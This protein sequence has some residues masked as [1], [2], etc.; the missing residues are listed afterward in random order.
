MTCAKDHQSVLWR[1]VLKKHFNLIGTLPV[2]HQRRLLDL[3]GSVQ[4][5]TKGVF[6]CL[7]VNPLARVHKGIQAHPGADAYTGFSARR[8]DGHQG[9]RLT[10]GLY[11]LQHIEQQALLAGFMALQKYMHGTV[12]AQAKGQRRVLGIGLFIFLGRRTVTTNHCPAGLGQPP[13]LPG[14]LLL[15]A[16]ATDGSDC[17]AIKWNQHPGTRTPIGRALDL[18]DRGQNSIDLFAAGLIQCIQQGVQIRHGHSPGSYSVERG[19]YSSPC[20]RRRTTH[21][22]SLAP[23]VMS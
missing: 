17:L 21:A 14:Q 3:K 7:A 18:D 22:G 20:I 16:T 13:G 4:I 11:P 15:Q 1:D 12:A 19:Y 23:N 6:E 8:Q 10:A 2:N 9:G 5:A